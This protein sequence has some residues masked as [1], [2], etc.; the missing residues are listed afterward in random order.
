VRPVCL[1]LALAS[2]TSFTA[3]LSRPHAKA[4]AKLEALS[5]ARGQQVATLGVLSWRFGLARYEQVLRELTA[6]CAGW[7]GVTL[8]P[9]P[10]AALAA[11]TLAA[12][13]PAA[14]S[15]ATRQLLEPVPRA[16]VAALAPY[17]REGV[18]FVLRRGGRA[19]LADEMGL[20]KTV[21]AIAA[22]AAYVEAPPRLTWPS[23]LSEDTAPYTSL[24]RAPQA[25][26]HPN[27]AKRAPHL[28]HQEW[29]LLVA[30]PAS[31]RLHWRDELLRWLPRLLTPEVCRAPAQTP[32]GSPRPRGYVADA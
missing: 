8:E 7:H 17:Q 26:G 20:G 9:V 13:P 2:R 14:D 22:A 3:S 4:A 5:G 6:A 19:L 23:G 12:T 30:C 24:P 32:S 15:E 28:H 16:L 25:S 27:K 11:A 18:A 29:P 10:R 1:T 31:A 21:Q